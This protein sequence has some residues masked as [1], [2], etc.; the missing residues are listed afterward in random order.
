M[1][2]SPSS[3][4][5]RQCSIFK[6]KFIDT[7]CDPGEGLLVAGGLR[8]P[9]RDDFPRGRLYDLWNTKPAEVAERE[10]RR[11]AGEGK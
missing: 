2:F 11:R 5:P 1:F 8:I 3:I 10:M 9:I 7:E 6:V 4:C